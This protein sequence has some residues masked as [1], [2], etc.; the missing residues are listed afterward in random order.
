MDTAKSF[1]MRGAHVFDVSFERGASIVSHLG[2]VIG[3]TRTGAIHL[4]ARWLLAEGLAEPHH[5]IATFVG[6]GP[7][8]SGQVGSCARWRVTEEDKAGLRLVPFDKADIML[9]ELADA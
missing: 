8:M 6:G 4:A 3:R 5:R 1:G 2:E 9:K 7:S